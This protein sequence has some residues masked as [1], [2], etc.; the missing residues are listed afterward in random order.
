MIKLSLSHLSLD[1]CPQTQGSV[2]SSLVS[3][4]L[5][6]CGTS[7]CQ[8]LGSHFRYES[9]F[10]LSWWMFILVSKVE[11]NF[12][13]S[14]YLEFRFDWQGEMGLFQSWVRQVAKRRHVCGQGQPPLG[15]HVQA[16]TEWQV[17]APLIYLRIPAKPACILLKKK[18]KTKQKSLFNRT[19]CDAPKAFC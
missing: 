12:P 9:T 7:L 16:V 2:A 5:R 3:L 18:N 14:V 19:I 4:K 17:T 10:P 13:L 6:R 8:G 1:H 15:N 11:L